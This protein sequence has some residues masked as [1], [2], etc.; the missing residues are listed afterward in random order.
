MCCPTQ[1][2]GGGGDEEVGVHSQQRHPWLWLPEREN[3]LRRY[4]RGIIGSKW[5]AAGWMRG[6]TAGISYNQQAVKQGGHP[7]VITEHLG[8]K[9]A[10]CFARY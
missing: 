5:M 3:E 9:R 1:R 7:K 6:R 10:Q 4:W 2:P 8:R